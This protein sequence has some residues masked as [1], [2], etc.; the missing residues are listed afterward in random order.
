MN[1]ETLDRELEGMIGNVGDKVPGLGVIIY[2]GG[3]E[4]YSKFVGRRKINPD[5][6]ITRRTRFRAASVSKMFTDSSN[7]AK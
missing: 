5:K 2:A 6:P 7:A 3:E 1:R 4:V